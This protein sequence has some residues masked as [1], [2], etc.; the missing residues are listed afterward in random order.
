MGKHDGIVA[1]VGLGALGLGVWY[2]FL[3][4]KGKSE[5]DDQSR[6]LQEQNPG[7]SKTEADAL[8]A[9]QNAQNA[10][11]QA[12]TAADAV[13]VGAA[14]T[15]YQN[16]EGNNQ[17]AQTG[18]SS[19]PTDSAAQAAAAQAAAA[20]AQARAALETSLSSQLT[21]AQDAAAK[22][23]GCLETAWASY[24]TARQAY[25][26]YQAW[27]AAHCNDRSR[28]AGAL[29]K[30]TNQGGGAFSFKLGDTS[31]AGTGF[32]NEAGSYTLYPGFKMTLF[33]NADFT[34]S[35]FGP[36]HGDN[37]TNIGNLTGF[38]NCAGSV[39]CEPYP[40]AAIY[41]QN[42]AAKL[43][44]ADRIKLEVTNCQTALNSCIERVQSVID[45]IRVYNV[46]SS[47][48][49]TSESSLQALRNYVG[50]IRV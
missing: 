29:F 36:V 44:S 50:S 33:S 34:G 30:D 49:A 7:M 12:Q 27:I 13:G 4:P 8:A 18:A 24:Q 6:I 37:P 42:L 17:Q 39:R 23:K 26:D 35:M 19:N 25:L 14:G 15:A 20:A 3:R 16:A 41:Q 40:N 9:A 31:L 38:N 21:V 32:N 43:A 11:T 10:V 45:Q 47:R 1:I 46:L 28:V 48:V 2:F 5:I 22:A